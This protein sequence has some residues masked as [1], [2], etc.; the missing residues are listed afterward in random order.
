MLVR[1]K[2]Q[3]K[4]TFECHFNRYVLKIFVSSTS[5][6]YIKFPGIR[7]ITWLHSYTYVQVIH[8][9]ECLLRPFWYSVLLKLRHE[10]PMFIKMECY[11]SL[12]L[13]ARSCIL[14]LHKEYANSCCPELANPAYSGVQT[15]FYRY[16][17]TVH[18]TTGFA[19]KTIFVI[20]LLQKWF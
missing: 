17:F 12:K 6:T 16:G 4:R 11:Y 7:G 14:V 15:N 3:P 10:C 2:T 20:N 19:I 1:R 9:S 13:T 8:K 18:I 5:R